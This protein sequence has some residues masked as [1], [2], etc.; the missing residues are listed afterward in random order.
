MG[1]ILT[2]AQWQG[3]KDALCNQDLPLEMI[4]FIIKPLLEKYGYSPSVQI[5]VTQGW[6][7]FGTRPISM[8]SRKAS[9]SSRLTTV[10]GVTGRRSLMVHLFR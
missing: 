7:S 9:S 1:L 6:H 2:Q 10:S 4:D 3:L 5:A 8:R